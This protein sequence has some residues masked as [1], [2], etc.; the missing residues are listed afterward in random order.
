MRRDKFILAILGYVSM[1][2]RM[3]RKDFKE[4]GRDL[5][6]NLPSNKKLKEEKYMSRTFTEG[7]LKGNYQVR[8]YTRVAEA[9]KKLL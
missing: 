5:Y 8:V 2:V 9:I 3:D 7:F 4:L 1:N 6:E